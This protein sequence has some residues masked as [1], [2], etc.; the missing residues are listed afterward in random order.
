M[1]DLK[2]IYIVSSGCPRQTDLFFQ[3][4]CMIVRAAF[5]CK[6][7]STWADN[8]FRQYLVHG[9]DDVAIGENDG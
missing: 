9:V 8:G 2:M 3:S 4:V 5:C 1:F 7:R 6:H